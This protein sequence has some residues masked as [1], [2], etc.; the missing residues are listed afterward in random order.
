[1]HNDGSFGFSA[2]RLHPRLLKSLCWAIHHSEKKLNVKDFELCVPASANRQFFLEWFN[3]QPPPS[4]AGVPTEGQI[5][6]FDTAEDLH[7]DGEDDVEPPQAAA[8]RNRSRQQKLHDQKM[9]KIQENHFELIELCKYNRTPTDEYLSAQEQILNQWRNRKRAAKPGR[10]NLD[11]I[12][13]VADRQK[14]ESSHKK[15]KVGDTVV[16]PVLQLRERIRKKGLKSGTYVEVVSS[17]RRERWF[18]RIVDGRVLDE[19]GDDPT[20]SKALWCEA[21]SVN[22]LS[23]THTTP[24]KCDIRSIIDAGSSAKFNA[25]LQGR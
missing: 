11:R 23:H 16:D 8:R 2:Q 6:G 24:V 13:G 14:G 9:S 22:H 20:L 3:V 25:S 5:G 19:N 15:R 4:W 17:D 1:M 12:R 7:N 18:M 10:P 21:N